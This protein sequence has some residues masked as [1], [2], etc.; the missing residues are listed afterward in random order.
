VSASRRG[1]LPRGAL[2]PFTDHALAH[3]S[4]R[5]TTLRSAV[6]ASPY[7]T[8]AVEFELPPPPRPRAERRAPSLTPIAIGL[9]IPS[10]V[11]VVFDV[12]RH[13][14]FGAESTLALIAAVALPIFVHHSMKDRTSSGE[15][16]RDRVT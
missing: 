11:R 1:I 3:G 4:P 16:T 7:R 9:W 5:R 12:S 6:E 10:A 13:V 14:T 8:S 2:S 15:T